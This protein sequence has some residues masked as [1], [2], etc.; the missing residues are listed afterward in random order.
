[1]LDYASEET[2][3]A[4]EKLIEYELKKIES[5][6]PKKKKMIEENLKLLD[7]GKRDIYV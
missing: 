3:K 4:G 7:E 5:T 2:R 1:M 6:D